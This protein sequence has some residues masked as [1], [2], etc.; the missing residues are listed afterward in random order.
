MIAD[1]CFREPEDGERFTAN[2][3]VSHDTVKSFFIR[4]GGGGQPRLN[5][6]PAADH[7]PAALSPR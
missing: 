7:L 3:D 5:S 1:V 6:S 2:R 4:S